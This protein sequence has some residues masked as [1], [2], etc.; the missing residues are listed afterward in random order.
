MDEMIERTICVVLRMPPMPDLRILH[1]FPVE[2]DFTIGN[3]LQD[4]DKHYNFRVDGCRVENYVVEVSLL[5][6]E[7]LFQCSHFQ[8][9]MYMIRD[10][11]QVL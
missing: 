9:A 8:P 7:P 2:P 1:T 3:L 4:L 11:Q 10:N 5:E 6:G